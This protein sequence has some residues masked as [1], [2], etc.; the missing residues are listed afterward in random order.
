MSSAWDAGGAGDE[1]VW[2]TASTREE[3]EIAGA[4]SFWMWW[5]MPLVRWIWGDWPCLSSVS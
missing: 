2:D 3:V 1:G 5:V 4:G